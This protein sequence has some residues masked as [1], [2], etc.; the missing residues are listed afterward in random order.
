MGW[1][2]CVFAD[3]PLAATRIHAEGLAERVLVV[4]L[5]AHH[6]DGTASALEDR[7][8]VSILDLYQAHLFPARKIPVRFPLPVRSGLSGGEYLE[9]LKRVL[10]S[11]L[12]E[13]NPSL[14]IYNAG[15]DPF[16]ADPLAGLRLTRQDLVQRDLMVVSQARTAASRSPWSSPGILRPLMEDSRR[17]HQGQS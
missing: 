12:D 8:W 3:I 7:P 14:L 4:D 11:A 6:G 1:R 15:S 2:F 10:P 17:G 16:E 13:V 9:I 5:D